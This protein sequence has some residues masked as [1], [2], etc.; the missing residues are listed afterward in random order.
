M[1]PTSE[2]VLLSRVIV[3]LMAVVVWAF[4]YLN[5]RLAYRMVQGQKR[6]AYQLALIVGA[7]AVFLLQVQ[8]MMRLAPSDAYGNYFAGFVFIECGGALVVLFTTLFRERARS[9]K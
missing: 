9:R 2:T 4:F 5:G 6:F 3:P 8:V 7:A 1:K